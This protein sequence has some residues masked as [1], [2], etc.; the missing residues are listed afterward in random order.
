MS[1]RGGSGRVVGIVVGLVLIAAG[2]AAVVLIDWRPEREEPPEPVRPLK[3]LVVGDR[4][5]AMRSYPARVRAQQEVTLAFQV[6]G[7]IHDLPIWRGKP[8]ERGH[9]L[10]ELDLRDFDARLSFAQAR[11]DQVTA[12]F[13]AARQAFD[14][15]GLNMLEFTRAR[16]A[17][18]LADAELQLAL[19]AIEDAT[20]LAPFGGL[21]AEVFVD[22]FENVQV[23]QP[24]LRLQD[25]AVIRVEV[26]VHQERVAFGRQLTDAFRFA[27]RFDFLPDREYEATLFEYTTEA[28]ATTQTFRAIFELKPPQDVT[29]FPGMTA[30]VL[31]YAR[32]ESEAVSSQV[33]LP[34]E[35]VA[36]D[37]FG[38]HV[39]WLVEGQPDGT[40]IVRRRVVQAG[41]V[42]EGTIVITSGVT[43]GQTLA[44]AGV[45]HLS[46]G[47]RVRPIAPGIGRTT[48]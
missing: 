25:S 34:V 42:A 39:V 35:A 41:E 22:A 36:I 15:G 6:Q 19:K 26:N 5:P 43:A 12:E 47:Q 9:L 29:V 30:T 10:A 24:I 17:V 16:T 37:N 46:D 13:D 45:H 2:I 40:A 1:T 11:F 31:E 27:V 21:V 48:P 20:M 18:Q 28:A 23:G 32:P 3:T 14:L 33:Y 8:V 44:A 38:E 4:M 7:V